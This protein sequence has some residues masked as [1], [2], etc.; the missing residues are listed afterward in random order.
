LILVHDALGYGYCRLS[1]T[2]A[3]DGCL[4]D[5]ERIADGEEIDT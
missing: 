3:I 2:V 1:L 4:F 5:F